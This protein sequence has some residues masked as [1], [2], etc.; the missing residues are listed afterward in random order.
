MDIFNKS[1]MNG[2]KYD[3]DNKVI[4]IDDNTTSVIWVNVEADVGMQAAKM[5]ENS[6]SIDSLLIQHNCKRYWG[7]K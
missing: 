6:E 3:S 1:N 2:F 5:Y 7:Y 4:Q